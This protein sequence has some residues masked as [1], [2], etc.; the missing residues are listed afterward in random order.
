MIS[1]SVQ[2]SQ[3]CCSIYDQSFYQIIFPKVVK[4]V[5]KEEK[6]EESNKTSSAQAKR[7]VMTNK[8]KEYYIFYDGG[9]HWCS[10]CHEKLSKLEDY[11]KH[12]HQPEHLK[13]RPGLLWCD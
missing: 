8:Q 4:E 1:I 2:L 7:A 9:G 13:V 12:C 6:K 5:K 3:L 10:P 11:M